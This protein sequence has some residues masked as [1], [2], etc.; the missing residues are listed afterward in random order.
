VTPFLGDSAAVGVAIVNPVAGVA[1]IVASRVLK[2][3]LGRMF[4][5][6]YGV[7]GGWNDPKVAK[8]GDAVPASQSSPPP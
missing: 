8:L 5:Y 6:E 3:P 2:D 7:T 1:A 4:A